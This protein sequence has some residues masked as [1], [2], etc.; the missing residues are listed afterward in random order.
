MQTFVQGRY[1]KSMAILRNYDTLDKFN[2]AIH[3]DNIKHQHRSTCSLVVW[4][5]TISYYR[6]DCSLRDENGLTRI[7]VGILS[8]H[9]T[10]KNSIKFN[11][12]PLLQSLPRNY[13]KQ[14]LTNKSKCNK[15]KQN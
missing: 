10:N 14:K 8:N 12:I 5:V 7:T 1:P 6:R 9:N 4:Y 11:S 3:K 13:S 2:S 15:L